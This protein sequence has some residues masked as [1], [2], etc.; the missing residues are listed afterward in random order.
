M[1]TQ[2]CEQYYSITVDTVSYT[3]NP[4]IK[5]PLRVQIMK[6]LG[7]I[8]NDT[9]FNIKEREINFGKMLK[10]TNIYVSRTNK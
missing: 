6:D 2:G 1:L 7:A 5:F 3:K 4:E 9:E 10:S 8:E